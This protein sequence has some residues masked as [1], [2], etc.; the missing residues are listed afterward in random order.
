MSQLLERLFYSKAGQSFLSAV[1]V[2]PAVQL[3]R[4]QS[5]V[6]WVSGKTGVLTPPDQALDAVLAE[7]G[8][9]YEVVDSPTAGQAAAESSYTSIIM[10]ATALETIHDLDQ[11]KQHFGLINGKLAQSAHIVIIGRTPELCE[12]IEFAATQE[13]LNGFTR[14]L[15]K[16]LGRKGITVNL[17]YAAGPA[18]A[19]WCTPLSFFLSNKSAYISGQPLYLSAIAPEKAPLQDTQWEQPLAGKLAL[20]TGAAQGIGAAIAQTLARDGATVIGLDIPAAQQ[21][22]ESTMATLGGTALCTDITSEHAV[23]DIQAALNQQPIDILVH[24][25]GVTRD[26]TLSKMPDHWW[27]MTLNINLKAPMTVTAQL[28]SAHMLAEEARVICI[29]SI[30]G[31]AG[32]VG[33]TNYAASKAGVIG[34]VHQQAK[35]WQGSNKTINAI[36]PGFIETQMTDQIPFMTREIGRRMNS[37]SQGG[38][39]LDVA[40][41]VAF[42]AQPQANALNGQV[43]RVCGQSLIGA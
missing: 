7:C 37:L 14:A 34:F 39:P 16:E 32:N 41:G 38:L 11:L 26:K 30:S 13:A 20:I 36:A 15:A 24:N 22:L 35:M 18:N 27:Q 4:Y 12:G 31:I 5:E 17:L 3:R 43:L 9:Q 23:T 8:I 1:G 25:A 19:S 40:E 42:F 2:K 6:P 28:D 10:D 29:S 21:A 33:Q